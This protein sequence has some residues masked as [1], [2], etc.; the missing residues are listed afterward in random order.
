MPGV[1]GTH[2]EPFLTL[3]RPYGEARTLKGLEVM[4]VDPRTTVG[5]E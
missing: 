5:V 2:S 3:E 4:I 1:G